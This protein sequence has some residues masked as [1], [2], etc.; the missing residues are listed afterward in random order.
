MWKRNR[1]VL[2]LISF[3]LGLTLGQAVIF[4]YENSVFHPWTWGEDGN[5]IIANCYGEDFNILYIERAVEYWEAKAGEQIGFIEQNPPKEVC[6]Y[7]ML[8]GFIILRKSRSLGSH[9]IASTKRRTALGKIRAAE[10][11]FSP[12]SFK[13]DYIVEHELGHALG[14]Q[15]IEEE[16]HI[17]YPTYDRM[18]SKFWLP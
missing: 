15:H 13:L 11:R 16:G 1:I 17:M 5:P 3:A 8:D 2:T 6:D 7:E 12:G 14:Y 18:G 10:I 9:T 4:S